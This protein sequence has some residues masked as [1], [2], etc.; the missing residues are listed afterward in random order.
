MAFDRRPGMAPDRID[1]VAQVQAG[2]EAGALVHPLPHQ[3]VGLGHALAMALAADLAGTL[4]I[5]AIG[6]DDGAV[7]TA[8]QAHGDAAQQRGGIVDVV[9]TGTVAGLAG[10]AQFGHG[11]LEACIAGDIHRLAPG[12]ARLQVAVVGHA[13]L[14]AGVV[15]ENAVLVPDRDLVVKALL[16]R[17]QE[18]GIHVHPALVG[19]V[20]QVVQAH[21]G[22]VV[23]QARHVLLVA[24]G[25]DGA[26]DLKTRQLFAGLQ[27]FVFEEVAVAIAN[28]AHAHAP[29]VQR[30][31]VEAALHAGGRGLLRHGAVIGVVPA[32]MP[33]LVAIL[34]GLRAGERG[35]VRIER[36]IQARALE[37]QQGRQPQ[38]QRGGC[39]QQGGSA[40]YAAREGIL[41][42]R[43]GKSSRLGTT[44]LGTR[45][46]GSGRRI[47]WLMLRYGSDASM[48]MASPAEL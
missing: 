34:A 30:L 10:D 42:K 32:V 11:R 20:P 13:R 3:V 4:R 40:R 22:A 31:A 5:E 18:G 23:G 14:R 35:L 33:V 27:A 15:A 26:L 2:T 25:A 1:V 17:A 29:I 46:R 24:V 41:E 8:V 19:V 37:Q 39:Q 38:D 45:R 6:V 48:V 47:P 16:V 43:G 9:A 36:C 28:R 7:A 21:I 44:R 12:G